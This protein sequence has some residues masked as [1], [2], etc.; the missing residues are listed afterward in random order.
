M[1]QVRKLVVRS[2]I[3]KAMELVEGVDGVVEIGLI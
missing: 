3:V 1:A 2:F